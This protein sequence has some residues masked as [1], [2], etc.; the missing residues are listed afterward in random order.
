M[1]SLNKNKK[2]K[3]KLKIENLKNYLCFNYKIVQ[4]VVFGETGLVKK[5]FRLKFNKI[6]SPY[7]NI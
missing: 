2:K 6:K 4:K 3:L 1:Q 7:F 5:V